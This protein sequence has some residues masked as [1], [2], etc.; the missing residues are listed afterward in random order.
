VRNRSFCVGFLVL[1]A[2]G[3]VYFYWYPLQVLD[4]ISGFNANNGSFDG[5]S[6]TQ[7]IFAFTVF[8]AVLSL[9]LMTYWITQQEAGRLRYVPVALLVAYIATISTTM[10][11]EQLYANLWDLANKSSYWYDFYYLRPYKVVLTVVDMALLFVAYP[12]FRRDNIPKV[13]LFSLLTLAMFIGW[14][15]VG[16]GEP[17]SSAGAY[18]FNASSRIFS[19]AAIAVSVFPGRKPSRRISLQDPA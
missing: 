3:V 2:A 4:A 19:Q 7:Q 14:Y 13:A 18:F 15:A 16:F 11:Y 9:M 5:S 6:G 17:T 1:L 10:W 8:S 12:W